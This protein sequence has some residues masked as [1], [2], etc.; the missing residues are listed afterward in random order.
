VVALD[1]IGVVGHDLAALAAQYERLGFTLTRV[2]SPAADA[3]PI[4]AQCCARAIWS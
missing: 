3:S 4:V 2:R 1:H